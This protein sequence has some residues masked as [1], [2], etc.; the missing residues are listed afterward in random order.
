[1]VSCSLVN[2]HSTGNPSSA[3][4][5]GISLLVV[6]VGVDNQRRAIGVEQLF[7]LWPIGQEVI[8]RV[9]I[10]CAV[11]CHNQQGQVASMGTIGIL[12]AMFLRIGVVVPSCAGEIRRV[13]LPNVMDVDTVRA[14]LESVDPQ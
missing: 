10:S 2:D 4:T 7:T 1:M 12:Q 5:R 6:R 13:A 9:Q 14:G 11:L 8:R 3:V